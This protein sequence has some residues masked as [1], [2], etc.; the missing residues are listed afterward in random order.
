MIEKD[1]TFSFFLLLGLPHPI[2]FPAILKGTLAEM[3]PQYTDEELAAC[4]EAVTNGEASEQQPAIAP[5]PVPGLPELP[6]LRNYNIE[7]DA[8]CPSTLKASRELIYK[9]RGGFQAQVQE[10]KSQN[11]FSGLTDPAFIS[12]DIGAV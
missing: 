2:S 7:A 4:S 10:N 8:N 9:G 5:D 3:D 12:P 1:R 6:E 11:N